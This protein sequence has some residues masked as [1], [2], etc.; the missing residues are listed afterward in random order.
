MLLGTTNLLGTILLFLALLAT[1]LLDF[2]QLLTDQAVLGF[3]SHGSLQ[4]IINQGKASALATTKGSLEAENK[5]GFGG[6]VVHF[7]ELGADVDFGAVSKTGMNNVQDHLLTEEE[8]IGHEL[9]SAQ[10]NR[11]SFSLHRR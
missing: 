3:E 11:R 9:A 5:G 6:N 10:S 1:S 2:Q 8:T 7:G 4:G